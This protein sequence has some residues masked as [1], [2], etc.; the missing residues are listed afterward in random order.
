ML[1]KVTEAFEVFCLRDLGH[2]LAQLWNKRTGFAFMV[3][4]V[5][6]RYAAK[7][8]KIPAVKHEGVSA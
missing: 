7:T 8:L 3:W 2:F 6:F 1:T 4:E 5:I